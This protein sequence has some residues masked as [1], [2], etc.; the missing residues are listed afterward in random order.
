M[1]G[2]DIFDLPFSGVENEVMNLVR[3][4]LELRH[5]EAGDPDGKLLPVNPSEGDAAVLAMLLR[6]RQ[7]SDRVDEIMSRLTL[8]KGRAKRVQDAARFEAEQ[9]LATAQVTNMG[10]RSFESYSTREERNA[11]AAL[12][13][14]EQRRQAHM[15]ERM[16][17]ITSDAYEVVKGIHWSL[18]AIR[19][20]LRA[21]LHSLQFESS[22]ER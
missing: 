11:E 14:V 15:A 12:D 8:A 4:A 22:L 13:S 9:A 2:L 21:T 17:S 5:G 18:N 19:G 1:S 3:E 16:V 7:R 20:D 10:R 6:V